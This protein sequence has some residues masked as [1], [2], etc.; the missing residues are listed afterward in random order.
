M[1]MVEA[2]VQ[3]VNYGNNGTILETSAAVRHINGLKGVGLRTE[4]IAKTMKK[5]V[6]ERGWR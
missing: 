1:T 6:V 4:V 2:N 5:L 3:C